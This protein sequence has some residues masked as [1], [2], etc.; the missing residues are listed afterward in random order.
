MVAV[1]LALDYLLLLGIGLL[2]T[3]V[4]KGDGWLTSEDDINTDLA[5]HRTPPL[6]DASYIGVRPGQH[7]RPSS[8]RCSSSPSRSPSR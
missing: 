2:L 1:L 7:R 8:A 4:F 6:N 5:H 3:K